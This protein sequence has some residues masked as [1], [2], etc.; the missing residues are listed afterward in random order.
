MKIYD[1]TTWQEA[2]SLKVHNGSSFASAVK[3]WVYDSGWQISYPNYPLSISSPSITTTSG[4]T[5]RIGCVYSISTGSWNTNDA[6]LPTSYSYQWTRSGTNIPGATTNS[7][8][9]VAADAETIIACRVTATNGRGSTPITVSTAI[10]ML[11]QLMSITATNTTQ[12]V[13]VPT[14]SFTPNGL[15]YSGSWTAPSYATTYETTSGG[16]AGSPSVNIANRTFSGTGTAG[17]ASFS[18]RAVNNTRKITLSWAAATGA[19]SYDIYV[20]GSLYASNIGNVTS[21]DYYPTDDNARNFTVYPRSATI[22]GY[23]ASTVSPVAAPATRSDYGTAS[24]SL[25]QPNATSPTYASG[26]ASSS[27]LYVSWGGSSYATKY[28]VYWTTAASI[29][30]DPASSYDAETASTSYTFSGSFT[31]GYTYYFYISASGDNNQW[32]PYSSYKASGTVPYT[33]P[34]TPSPSTS[35]VTS[36]S[37]LISWSAVSGAS[38]YAVSVGTSSGGSDI[39]NVSGVTDTSRGV[40]GL[41]ASTPYYVTVTAYKTGYGYGSGGTASATTQ[42]PDPYISSSPLLQFER[43]STQIKWGFDNPSFGGALSPV[44]IEWEVMTGQGTG[45]TITSGN[46]RN[47]STGT[48]GITV[49]GYTWNYVVRSTADLPY[50]ASAR[51]LRCRFYGLNTN[52]WAIVNGPWSSWV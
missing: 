52:T 31:E 48:S 7:Y 16:T 47:Y 49:N 29:G 42:A 6:Y 39:L 27:S 22:Q 20:Q 19:V 37:F 13:S 33:A 1:G 41:S 10:T 15:S 12:S 35:S 51:Y 8:T 44:G 45:T 32:S 9:T 14:V 43:T 40:T 4:I 30:L 11:P 17:S 23:G 2:K 28:R 26:S 24:G 5:G 18:V 34:G 21:Y 50:S 25:V 46:T 38:S 3:G 36:N